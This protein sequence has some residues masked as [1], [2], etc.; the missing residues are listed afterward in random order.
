MWILLFKTY[1][2][3]WRHEGHYFNLHTHSYPVQL[4]DGN[5]LLTNSKGTN[6]LFS[7]R[8]SESIK[9]WDFQTVFLEY[10]VILRCPNSGE[11]ISW[12]YFQK[13]RVRVTPG[14]NYPQQCILQ[15]AS[16]QLT[17]KTPFKHQVS[18]QDDTSGMVNFD[19]IGWPLRYS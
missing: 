9:L 14:I 18:L 6:S 13:I 2:I 3:F 8:V 5:Q 11:K 15:T 17:L 16:H 12:R 7:C 1:K 10:L 4:M 19:G